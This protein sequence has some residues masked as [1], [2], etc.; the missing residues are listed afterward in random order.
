MN[1]NVIASMLGALMIG[2]SSTACEAASP[3]LDVPKGHWAYDAVIVLAAEGI[4]E[5][6]GDGTFRGDRN[7]TRYEAATIISKLLS[8]GFHPPGGK[9]L[10]Y[11]DVPAEHWA[12]KSVMSV[13][14]AGL[15][16]GYS[17]GTF[18]GDQNITRYEMAIMI[19]KLLTGGQFNST[20]QIN[21]FLDVPKG[22]WA[23]DAV[24]ML[25]LK[26]IISGYGDG[27]FRGNKNV[28]RYEAA[29]TIARLLMSQKK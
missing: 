6:Y 20:E 9:S 17:D 5:G 29:M 27:T 16:E 8:K 28:T 7:I 3:F 23:Y 11:E 10:T 1:K 12:Y 25:A 22:H 4:N 19:A 2:V 26:G 15:S 14:R 13:T 24:T 18:R 21:P